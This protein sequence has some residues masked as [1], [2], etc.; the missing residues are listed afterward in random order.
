VGR[1]LRQTH[2]ALAEAVTARLRA[3]TENPR[4]PAD[5]RIAALDALGALQADGVF[6]L[7]P[8]LLSGN[9]ADPS[10][11][12]RQA[13]L[14][15]LGNLRGD[16]AANGVELITAALRNDRDRDVRL[17]A[18]DALARVG[19]LPEHGG[20]L[21][22]YTQPRT[23]ADESVRLRAWDAF[24]ALLPRA[25][26]AQLNR[27]R[28]SLRGDPAR[29]AVLLEVLVAKLAQAPRPDDRRDLANFR[30]ELGEVYAKLDPAKAIDNFRAALTAYF[31]EGAGENVTVPVI[32]ALIRAY[33]SAKDYVGAAD[34]A[35]EMIRR[36]G[37]HQD[38]VGPP[39]RNEADR[40]R[41]RNESQ[42]AI[43]LI[44]AVLKMNPPLDERFQRDLNEIRKAVGGGQ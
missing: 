9:Q 12:V 34:F 40:L 10:P 29:L 31:N 4:N 14:R 27:E 5:V 16:D 1:D 36:D 32:Q 2:P 6:A 17:A 33:L 39:I 26:P 13:A 15:M 24:Q 8:R 19:N 41:E 38:T 25:T 20:L 7:A 18:L 23:E 44:D 37:S 43:R 42:D 21:L 22:E 11:A 28:Q 3:I 35:A 30:V